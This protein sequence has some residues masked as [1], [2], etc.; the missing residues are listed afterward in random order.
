[1]VSL[2]VRVRPALLGCVAILALVL[3][4]LLV[5]QQPGR[6]DPPPQSP[7]IFRETFETNEP[8]WVSEGGD[9]N[10]RVRMHDRTTESSH[11]GR[12]S[13]RIALTTG[14]GTHLYYSYPIGRALV[15]DDLRISVW[16]KSD[17]PGTQL[18]ARV[19]FPRERDPDTLQLLATLIPGTSYENAGHWNRL[20]ISRPDL[21][22][23]RQARLLRA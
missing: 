23:E 13:E 2:I 15:A 16:V 6:G 11:S 7:E 10:R 21:A 5:A 17:R 1:M 20:E 22:T 4:A 19:V 3:P 18:L 9:V 12:Q 8:G 14:S